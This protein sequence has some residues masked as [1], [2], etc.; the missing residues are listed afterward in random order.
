MLLYAKTDGFVQPNQTYQM[1]GNTIYVQTLDLN[2]KFEWIAK[3]LD[4]II[5]LIRDNA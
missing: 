1:S 2:C 4:A 3:Q 5:E